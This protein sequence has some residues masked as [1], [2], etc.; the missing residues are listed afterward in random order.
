M[1]TTPLQLRQKARDYPNNMTY[2]KVRL[3][4]LNLLKVMGGGVGWRGIYGTP[5][6]NFKGSFSLSSELRT[7]CFINTSSIFISFGL[8]AIIALLL[9]TDFLC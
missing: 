1:G 9:T 2:A 7:R 6:H 4:P 8:I 3:T 5:L